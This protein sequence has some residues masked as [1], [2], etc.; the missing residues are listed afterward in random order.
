MLV[1]M[2]PSRYV[3]DV[4]SLLRVVDVLVDMGFEDVQNQDGFTGS[5]G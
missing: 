3:K 5:Y 4:M 1:R 2:R